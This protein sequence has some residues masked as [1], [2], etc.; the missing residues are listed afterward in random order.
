[1]EEPAL[2][3][4]QVFIS[5]SLRQLNVRKRS[6]FQDI[7]APLLMKLL[8]YR[9]LGAFFLESLAKPEQLR[10]VLLS[11]YQVDD[12]VDDELLHIL[13]KPAHTDGALEVFLAFIMYD[14]GPIPE[15]FLPVLSQPSLIIWGEEDQFEPFELG[16]AMRHY[17]IVESFVPLPDVGHCAHD[18][19]PEQCNKLI[20]EF[21][22]K[23]MNR[24]VV[25]SG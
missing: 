9:P 8:S 12:A 6:W 13:G 4:A 18:E 21:F 5:P 22:Q 10:T 19:S 1:V 7:T 2:C 23:H 16:Q 14:D 25:P 24:I 20:G 15:D 17:S 3:A 11:A